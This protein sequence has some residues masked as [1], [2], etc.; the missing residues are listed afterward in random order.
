MTRAAGLSLSLSHSET[1]SDSESWSVSVGTHHRMEE[2]KELQ[3]HYWSLPELRHRLIAALKNQDVAEATFRF[4]TE[5]PVRVKVDAVSS[6]PS[7]PRTSPQRE[8]AFRSRVYAASPDYYQTQAAA[9]EEIR[10]RQTVRFS[11]PFDYDWFG[12]VPIEGS[13]Q[14]LPALPAPQAEDDD[15]PFTHR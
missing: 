14:V 9:L 5:K 10:T 15:E 1:H 6:P 3:E 11:R 7:Y 13:A 4:G 2:F 12:P 8:A